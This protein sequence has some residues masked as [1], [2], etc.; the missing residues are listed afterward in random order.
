MSLKDFLNH[1]F[2]K[3][4]FDRCLSFIILVVSAYV[5][6]YLGNYAMG[7]F[8]LCLVILIR[9]ERSIK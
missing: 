5:G 2:K 1:S 6:L 7:T 9:L 4:A 3:I 8:G